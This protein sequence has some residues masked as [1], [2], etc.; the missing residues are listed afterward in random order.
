ARSWSGSGRRP[1]CR[2]AA[3][4]PPGIHLGVV[5]DVVRDAGLFDAYYDTYLADTAEPAG[6]GAEDGGDAHE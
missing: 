5:D 4:L 3:T 1:W 6:E 2:S